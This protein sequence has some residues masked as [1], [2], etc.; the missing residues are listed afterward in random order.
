M[1]VV[2]ILGG[3][4]SLKGGR[5]GK[6]GMFCVVGSKMVASVRQ[7][8]GGTMTGVW[9]GR[10]VFLDEP[11]GVVRLIRSGPACLLGG[12]LVK[13]LVISSVSRLCWVGSLTVCGS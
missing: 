11:T 13:I 12:G 10:L 8:G 1:L 5:G 6:V 3:A 7:G 9:P 2:V 4:G